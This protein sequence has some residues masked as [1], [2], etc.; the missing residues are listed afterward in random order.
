MLRSV[1]GMG[2][3]LFGTDFPYLRRDL[4]VSCS[5][6]IE[7][8]PELNDDESRAILRGNALKLFPRFAVKAAASA[9]NA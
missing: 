8:S 7:A 2:Q 5:G 1:V 3:V 9:D 4:A 6:E